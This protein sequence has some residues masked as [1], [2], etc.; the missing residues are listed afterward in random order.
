M[1][2]YEIEIGG[3]VH[4]L[5]LSDEDAEAQGLE[6]VKSKQADKPNKARTPSN[7]S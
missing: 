6:P 1:H 2:V 3:V 7:K 4:T 5:Q